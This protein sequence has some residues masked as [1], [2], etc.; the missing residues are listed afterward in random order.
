MNWVP[1]GPCGAIYLKESGRAWEAHIWVL[2]QGALFRAYIFVY[3]GFRKKENWIMLV[4]AIDTFI[5]QDTR[6]HYYPMFIIY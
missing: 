4:N 1:F 2:A 3:L 5:S 6:T